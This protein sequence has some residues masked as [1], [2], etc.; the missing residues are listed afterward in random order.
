ML[1]ENQVQKPIALLIESN[2]THHQERRVSVEEI[3]KII[4]RNDDGDP[5]TDEKVEAIATTIHHLL[6]WKKG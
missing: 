5:L 2:L 6:E 3:I 4:N 1:C